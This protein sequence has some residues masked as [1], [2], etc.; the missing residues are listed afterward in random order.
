MFMNIFL[1]AVLNAEHTIQQNMCEDTEVTKLVH[2]H[3][4]GERPLA[5][6]P[7]DVC[8]LPCELPKNTWLCSVMLLKPD[9]VMVR[10]VPPIRD[11]TKGEML[12]TSRMYSMVVFTPLLWE[13]TIMLKGAS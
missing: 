1:V 3:V 2:M 12:W 8:V 4:F 9:P 6:N 10:R 11:P 7:T 13:F 5:R